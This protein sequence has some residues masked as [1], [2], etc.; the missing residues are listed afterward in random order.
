[1]YVPQRLARPPLLHSWRLLCAF[2]HTA[3][4]MMSLMM[5]LNGSVT[6]TATGFS[7]KAPSPTLTT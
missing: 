4:P 7:P 2:S 6:N 5:Y 1:M 3:L